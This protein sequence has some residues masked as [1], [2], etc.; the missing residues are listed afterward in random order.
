MRKFEKHLTL[1]T[2]VILLLL[3][4]APG[5]N[6]A[7]LAGEVDLPTIHRAKPLSP[8]FTF[9]SWGDTKSNTD[10]LA[11]LSRQA[12][13]L[14]PLFT[15]YTGDLEPSGFSSSQ[16]NTWKNAMNGNASNGMF[17]I[18]LPI[19]GNHD[20]ENT[21]GWQ[22]YFDMSKTASRVG[23]T[24]YSALAEDLTYSFDY[25]NSVFVGID[26]LGA[27]NLI[28]A[29][30]IAYLDK[31]LTAAEGRGLTHAFLFFHGP[32]YGVS[33]TANCSTRTCSTPDSVANL[34]K[35]LNK[36][37]I[38][39]AIFHGHE[40][41]QAFVHLDRSR[42]PEITHAYEEFITGS[43]GADRRMNTQNLPV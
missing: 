7:S 12:K 31:V 10:T 13:L 14:K 38:V 18:T 27:A 5:R 35:V 9:L 21:A 26:V 32:E 1:L 2:V 23:A 33:G 4:S 41:V 30:Q 16:M 3:A 24:N 11:E 29:N 37:P 28:N 8:S 20:A 43:A 15:L 6:I 34:I 36:H 19:R 40:H 22:S 42:I 17:D 25:G 39:S